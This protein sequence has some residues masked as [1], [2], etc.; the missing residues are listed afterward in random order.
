MQI[1]N[2]RNDRMVQSGDGPYK[3]AIGPD[4]EFNTGRCATLANRAKHMLPF[5]T[6]TLTTNPPTYNENK[7][8]K[9]DG[10]GGWLICWLAYYVASSWLGYIADE[11][12]MMLQVLN[13]PIDED[14]WI[15]TCTG[16]SRWGSRERNK[17]PKPKIYLVW[18]L[19]WFYFTGEMYWATY[20]WKSGNYSLFLG[21]T[22][23]CCFHVKGLLGGF[24]L[25]SG[26]PPHVT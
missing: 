21:P 15:E 26:Y 7:K 24:F 20:Q 18:T 1:K 8:W 10:R 23:S 6:S 13:W 22:L 25:V 16:A 11:I 4:G 17:L 3:M 14:W 2:H 19:D 5:Q 9:C 12:N